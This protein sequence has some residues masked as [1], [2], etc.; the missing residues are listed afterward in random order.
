MN[1]EKDWDEYKA[2]DESPASDDSPYITHHAGPDDVYSA[3]TWLEAVE[4]ASAL[5]SAALEYSRR[6]EHDG[7]VRAWATPYRREDAVTAGVI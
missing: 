4:V 5:N 2:W 3:R 1:A 7:L 6:T